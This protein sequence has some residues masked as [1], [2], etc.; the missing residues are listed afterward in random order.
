MKIALTVFF[1]ITIFIASFMIFWIQPLYT[2]MLLPILGGSPSVWNTSLFFYQTALFVGYAYS[3]FLTRKFNLKQQIYIHISIGALAFISLPVTVPEYEP[4]WVLSHPT[5]WLFS[6]LIVYVGPAFVVLSSTSPL[7]QR[8]YSYTKLKNAHDPYFL[9]SISNAGNIAALVLFILLLEPAIGLTRMLQGWSYSYAAFGALMLICILALIKFAPKSETEHTSVSLPGT[10]RW[11]AVLLLSFIPTSLLYGVTQHISFNI[12]STPLMWLMPLILYL[13]AFVIAFMR[14]RIIKIRLIRGL[15]LGMIAVYVLLFMFSV[16]INILPAW[17]VVPVHL[18][19]FF[20]SA[21][22]CLYKVADIRPNTKELTGFYLLV[23]LGGILAGLFNVI[24]APNIFT[25]VI[26]Y[27][28]MIAVAA[29]A[30]GS[31]VKDRKW[32]DILM[33][34]IVLLVFFILGLMSHK[35]QTGMHVVM[36]RTTA[37]VIV[38]AILFAHKKGLVFGLSIAAI[39]VAG[40]ATLDSKQVIMQ[41]RNFFGIYR[42]TSDNGKV[43]LTHGTISQGYQYPASHERYKPQSYYAKNTPMGDLFEIAFE[44]IEPTRIGVIGLGTGTMAAYGKEGQYWDFYELDPLVVDI[45]RE[46]FTY[47]DDSPAVIRTITGDGRI[48]LRGAP[49]NFYDLIILDAFQSDSIPIHIIT[50]EAIALYKSRLADNGVLAFHIS[51]FSLDL[52]PVLFYSA[53]DLGLSSIICFKYSQ[54]FMMSANQAI[55]NKLAYRG[56]CK[57]PEKGMRSIQWSDERSSILDVLIR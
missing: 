13:T 27:P 46:H 47:L 29:G 52:S 38:L 42:V 45:A 34:L 28:F 10:N 56:G 1:G 49:E 54:W 55:I 43:K 50:N 37:T 36:I 2:K 26:E 5:L 18:V 20:A 23:S 4:A 17:F 53:N 33:P 41:K 48:S 7:L 21:S 39:L 12:A 14:K 15:Q 6:I 35:V 57:K 16:D 51:N 19:L 44:N 31:F 9:Y 11:P 8:W 3:H 32:R 30:G 40:M 25:S 24:I 22:V